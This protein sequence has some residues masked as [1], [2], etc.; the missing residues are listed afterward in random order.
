MNK[1]ADSCLV[2]LGFFRKYIELKHRRK[3][4]PSPEYYSHA[5]SVAF[6]SLGFDEIGENFNGWADFI[7]KEMTND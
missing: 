2:G 1:I 5:G 4:L 6:S 3:A 7:S